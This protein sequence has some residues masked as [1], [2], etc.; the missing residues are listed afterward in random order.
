M[1]RE[2][3]PADSRLNTEELLRA[4]QGR[5]AEAG[6]YR[7]CQLLE[8]ASPERPPLGTGSRPQDDA[9]RFRPDPG[10]GF[11]AGELRAIEFAERSVT[12]RTRVLGLYGV[13]APLPTAYL[14]DISQRREGHEALEA[15][16]DIFNH[17]IFTQFYRVWRKYSY[18][19]T[20][21]TGGR[22]ETSQC[23][24][25]L[26]GL[27]IPGTAEQIATPV[28]RFLALLGVMR[29]PTR[30]A[31]GITALVSL[32]AQNTRVRVVGHW[33][34]R[35][36]LV[37]PPGLDSGGGVALD[38]GTPLG[39]VARDVSSQMLLVLSTDDPAEVLGWLPGGSLHTDLLVLLRVY[40]GW[41]CTA[42]LR[43][44]LPLNRMVPAALGAPSALLG[45][46]AVLGP[47][48]NDGQD[49][50]T[51]N[52]GHY[53]GLKNNSQD[54]KANHVAYHF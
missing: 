13:D 3:Q 47:I 45:L 11:P 30:N 28:S 12:V 39:A 19:A 5:V 8:Q 46:T 23:L 41:R 51:I 34:K 22:D 43:L 6:I 1:E 40:L 31:E 44:S 49:N 32:L 48:G 16:L 29:L 17:R 27:G 4:L 25:G 10:M 24:L 50:I 14:D 9:V 38:Q 18:P 15:F 26:I 7:F 53:Q 36:R 42:C 21:E 35:I 37:P 54:R 33:P 2:P 20:F 52:L